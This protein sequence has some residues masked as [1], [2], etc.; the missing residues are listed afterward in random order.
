MKKLIVPAG[1]MPFH[2]ND[3]NWMTQGSEE[4]I[5]AAVLPFLRNGHIILNGMVLVLENN[6]STTVTPGWIVIDNEILQFNGGTIPGGDLTQYSIVKNTTYSLDG[7]EV[8]ADNI[9]RDT[10]E[11]VNA[12]IEFGAGGGIKVSELYNYRLDLKPELKYTLVEDDDNKLYARKIGNHIHIEGLLRAPYTTPY[13]L[14]DEFRP[15]ELL[16]LQEI[17]NLEL[18]SGFSPAVITFVI[19]PNGNVTF[20]FNGDPD[21][22]R[23]TNI[24]YFIN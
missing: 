23:I 4:G 6:G 5:Q 17:F 19:S 13:V 10:Y 7:R 18:E 2:G 1:G 14:P 12:I 15:K 21:F 16:V 8:F 3:L 11:V 24:N 20:L 9:T 22:F